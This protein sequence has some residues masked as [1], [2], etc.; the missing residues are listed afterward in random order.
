MQKSSPKFE[1]IIFV[2]TNRRPQEARVCCNT[3]KTRTGE[4]L[5]DMLKT[6]VKELK[7]E[8]RIRVSSSG[9]QDSCEE[10]PNI[11]ISPDNVWLKGVTIEDVPQIVT[12]YITSHA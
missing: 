6:R 7:L 10:G 4:I 5:R 1:R 11:F 12:E 2:C 8:G 3:E 9:C